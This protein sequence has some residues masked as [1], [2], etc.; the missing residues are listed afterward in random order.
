MKRKNHYILVA[1]IWAVLTV[2]LQVASVV[3]YVEV[4]SGVGALL[5][6]LSVGFAFTLG[7]L[8]EKAKA[9]ERLKTENEKRLNAIEDFTNKTCCLK[10]D[11]ARILVKEFVEKLKDK[12]QNFIEDN[13][14]YD[15]KV[16]SGI[17][18]V[19]VIGVI[20]KNGEIISLGL[21]DELLDAMDISVE[22]ESEP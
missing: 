19:D 22:G 8:V 20:G 11:I 9:I 5:G 6:G 4:N 12:L 16:N 21:I 14:D 17:L 3:C 13:E 18:Y 2:A 1:I 7:R 15:G 10:C